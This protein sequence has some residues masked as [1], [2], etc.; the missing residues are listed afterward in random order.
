MDIEIDTQTISE[1]GFDE[2][3]T[4]KLEGL[5]STRGT[6]DVRTI[7]AENIVS[8]VLGPEGIMYV[9]SKQIKIDGRNREITLTGGNIVIEQE[10][11]ININDGGGININDGGELKM[12]DES[13]NLV[14]FLGYE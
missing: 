13:E 1:A 14:I 7:S 3:L 10:G 9:G 4:R 8:G 2:Y 5:F 12:R 11:G 6:V